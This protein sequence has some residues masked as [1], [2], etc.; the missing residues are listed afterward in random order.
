VDNAINGPRTR[1]NLRVDATSTTG[2]TIDYDLVHLRTPGPMIVW[3]NTTYTSLSAFS[4]MTSQETHGIEADP[5]WRDIAARDL[6]LAAGSPAIDSANSGASGHSATDIEGK[7]RVDVAGTPNTGAGPRLYDDRGA[8]EFQGQ[9][10]APVAALTVTPSTG[11]APLNVTADASASTDPDGDIASYRFDFGDGTPTVGPQPGA[12]A[13]HTYTSNGTYTVTVTVTDSGGRTSQAT[14]QVTVTNDQPPNAALSVTPS[15]GLVPLDVSADASASNDPDGTIVSYSFDF[16]DGSPVVGPQPG[17][18]ASHTYATAGTYTVTVTVTDDAGVTAQAT[19]DVTARANLV[20]NPGFEASTSGWNTSGSGSGVTLARV[21]GGHSGG[22]AGKLTRTGSGT[23]TCLLNDSPNWVGATTSGAYTASL[24]A[25]ADAP[26][27]TLKLRLR[28]YAGT[29]LVGSAIQEFTLSTS[30]QQFSVS[31]TPGSPGS[32]NLDFNAYVTG[33]PAGTCFYADDVLIDKGGDPPPPPPPPTGSPPTARLAVTP[34]SGTTP[35][36]VSADAS[37]STDPDGDI[38]S[39][40]FDFGDGSPVVG[41]QPGATASHTYTAGGTHTVTVTVTD[42]AGRTS[43]AT[44][45]VT[46]SASLI[47]NP[48]FETNTSGWNTSGSGSGVTLARVSGGHSGSW[49]AKLTNTGTSS[50]TCTLNDSPSWVGQTAAG[51]YTASLWVRADTPGATLKLRVREYNGSTLVGTATG[52]VALTTSW[53]Q[54]TVAHPVASPGSNLDLNAYVSGAAPG[55]CF[56][57]DDALYQH[58]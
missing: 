55:T 44:Q 45:Q 19:K 13:P 57:A 49:S 33:A 27:A 51:T 16:G 53:Q 30:W 15:T 14:A 3:G 24:W 46:V 52:T 28:E 23:G 5:H 10:E 47:G 25:R 50:A 34:A 56:Y 36:D 1:G 40:R 39:Y 20:G 54:V 37:T 22:W 42:G 41:P 58:G 26:G 11:K 4:T 29:A 32:S 8:Y 18:T 31:Y 43:Q 2:T 48:G 6:H 12:T 9:P 17:A 7:P 35:L 38:A 21:S